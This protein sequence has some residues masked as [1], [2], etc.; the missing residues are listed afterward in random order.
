MS[1]LMNKAVAVLLGIIGLIV[2]GTVILQ[3]TA[4]NGFS[5]S[6]V[7]IGTLPVLIL[8]FVTVGIAIKIFKEAYGG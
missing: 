6:G 4:V 5:N 7:Y 2:A 1:D 8:G 3:A